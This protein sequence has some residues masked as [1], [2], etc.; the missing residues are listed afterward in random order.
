MKYLKTFESLNFTEDRKKIIDNTTKEIDK[1][2]DEYIKKI[3]DCVTY[4][5]DVYESDWYDSFSDGKFD[6]EYDRS[7]KWDYKT[8]NP[9]DRPYYTKDYYGDYRY[10]DYRYGYRRYDDDDDFYDF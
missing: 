4:L 5:S 9:Y 7:K 6:T 10:G 3:Q 8:Y 1:L 2:K